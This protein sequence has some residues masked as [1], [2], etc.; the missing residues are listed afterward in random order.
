MRIHD[1][2]PVPG[3]TKA[4]KRVGRGHGSGQGK[5][6]GYGHKGQKARSGAKGAAFEGGQMPLARRVPKRGFHNIFRTEYAI[7]NIATLES[8]FDAGAVI[9]AEAIVA[10]GL[11]KKTLAGVKIL[12]DGSLTKQFTV[13]ASKFSASAKAAIEAAGGTAEVV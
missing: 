9:D 7:I 3:S 4:R 2:A 12:G 1:L 5:T 8:N 13:K 6:A 10:A 11:L